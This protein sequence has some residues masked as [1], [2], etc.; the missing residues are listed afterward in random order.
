MFAFFPLEDISVTGHA[1]GWHSS[2][3][4]LLVVCGVLPASLSVEE[5]GAILRNMPSTSDAADLYMSIRRLGE[6]LPS[7]AQGG[8]D[9]PG[10][11]LVESVRPD[12]NGLVFVIF[13]RSEM[14]YA[15]IRLSNAPPTSPGVLNAATLRELNASYKIHQVLMP[16]PSWRPRE[17]L[18]RLHAWL[19][20][21]LSSLQM[22]ESSLTQRSHLVDQIRARSMVVADMLSSSDPYALESPGAWASQ[23]KF[24]NGLWLILNDLVV[25]VILG[26]FM[27]QQS[28]MLGTVLGSFCMN[29]SIRFVRSA[30]LW[31]DSWPAGLK[32]NTELSRFLCKALLTV[33]DI[34]AD[35]V[36]SSLPHLPLLVRLAGYTSYGGLTL[37]LSLT[38]DVLR[39]FALPA[40]LCH[41]IL[42]SVLAFEARTL[43][44]LW[45]LFRGKRYNTLR[46]H[47]DTYS[48]EVDQLLLGTLLF[49]LL[50][51]SFPTLA[52]YVAL[53]ALMNALVVA[54]ATVV[55][56]L[57]HAMNE[58]PLFALL[59][60]VKDPRRLPGSIWLRPASGYLMLEVEHAGLWALLPDVFGLTNK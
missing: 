44:S 43:R 57:L 58:F 15:G 30:L 3:R 52:V 37:A 54:L 48:Y 12:N 42:S 10:L 2:E 17:A 40:T 47:V 49:T 7:I 31:L 51:F 9:E 33:I 53:F 6:N 24:S 41:F 28:N 50:T 5:A 45:N 27:V 25:G 59:L 36:S 60:R 13:R 22:Q 32:L 18:P 16:L 29:R 19:S 11:N 14:G 26:R 21:N 4:Q 35:C 23:H 34:W 38:L 8:G 39:L 20:V 55:R 1:Y 46:G 56:V